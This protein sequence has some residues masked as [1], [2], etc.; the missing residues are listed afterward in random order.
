MPKDLVIEDYSKISSS[1]ETEVSIDKYT[2]YKIMRRNNDESDSDSDEKFD[3]Y[4][5]ESTTTYFCLN[6]RNS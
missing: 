5:P 4:K 3:W 2:K 1:L 6:L